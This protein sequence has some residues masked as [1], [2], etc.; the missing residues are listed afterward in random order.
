MGLPDLPGASEVFTLGR[1]MKPDIATIA[2]ILIAIVSIL[3]GQHLEGGHASSIMQLTAF[4]IVFGGTIGAVMISFP[5]DTFVSACKA[6]INVFAGPAEDL[7]AL[8]RELVEFATLSRR[9]GLLALQKPLE[10]VTDP[11]LKKGLQ[12]V[13]DGT[14]EEALR[15]M[16][17]VEI[18]TLEHIQESHAKVLEAAGGYA[19]TVGIIG[20]VLGL[21]HVME[22]LSDPSKLGG[23][24]ATAFVATVY[25]VGAANLFFLPGA[26]KLKI[27][28]E[29]HGKMMTIMLEAIV[30]IQQGE[31]PTQLKER[32]R[33]YLPAH[34]KNA[35]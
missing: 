10:H 24:I 1:D 4:M 26:G 23:G 25:G 2:G 21:I 15:E 16:L 33:G 20:A 29:E 12:L 14:Q 18:E 8:I 32:L 34:Q 3:G 13:V 22:N 27:K 7:P 11:F 6:M 9:D 28:K 19:P 30:A 35:I 17:E 5:L 31:N